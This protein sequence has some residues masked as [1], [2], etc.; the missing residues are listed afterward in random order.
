MSK[1]NKVF[2]PKVI[3]GSI[4]SFIVAAVGI[5][6]V[7]FPSVF[8]LEKKSIPELQIHYESAAD[9][10]KLW[11]FLEKN[12]GKPVKLDISFSGWQEKRAFVGEYVAK[13]DYDDLCSL[14]RFVYG[15]AYAEENEVF[16]EML[17]EG[18]QCQKYHGADTHLIYKI[19]DHVGKNIL[20]ED[21]GD[22]DWNNDEFLRK[23]TDILVFGTGYLE[24]VEAGITG[25]KITENG[26]LAFEA[27]GKSDFFDD[28][29]NYYAIDIPYKTGKKFRFDSSGISGTFFVH[30]AESGRGNSTKLQHNID[31]SD[32]ALLAAHKSIE[33]EPLDKKDLEMRNY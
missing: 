25:Y 9:G 17:Y 2:Q 6:A 5:I 11:K 12:V 27:F 28:T 32:P 21:L 23:N 19:T 15:E 20:N 22:T 16:Q 4:T 1:E 29:L 26:G 13:K 8:N 30:E 18:N 3:I 7:F 24:Y 31:G 14:K 33:L 10:I